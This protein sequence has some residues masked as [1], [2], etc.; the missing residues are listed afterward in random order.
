MGHRLGRRPAFL[1]VAYGFT[2]IMLGGTIPTPLYP[3]YQ[4]RLGFSSLVVTL[5]FAAY[6]A[7]TLAALLLCG[8]LS[9]QVGR[10]PVLL[11]GLG[12]AVA[13]TAVFVL[14]QDLLGLF[15]GRALSGF[16]VGLFTGA[17]TAALAELYPGADRGRA[18]LVAS[19]VQMGGLGL[20]PLLSGLLSQYAPAPTTLCYL[21][22][23]ALLAPVGLVL[24]VPETVA[25]PGRPQLR[26]QRLAVP[27]RIRA[28]FAAAGAAG[29]AAF[30]FLGLLTALVGRFL[31]SSLHSHSFALAGLMIFTLFLAVV[32][33]QLLG[34]RLPTRRALLAGLGLLP[35]G[36][37][38]FV[39]ALPTGS[40][41]LFVAGIVLGGLGVGL[42]F[43]AA[44]A[45]V[46][47]L[48]PEDQRAEVVSAFFV[49]AYLGITVP[50]IGIGILTTLAS[51]LVAAATFAG[52][53]TT[54]AAGAGW[55]IASRTGDQ[56]V[57]RAS[58]SPSV[59]G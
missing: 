1:V 44:L 2:V 36:L 18:T 38:L 10:R 14:G 23:L 24:V 34:A 15:V 59:R 42:A 3:I 50:V 55:V 21:A 45:L 9:D 39:L 22:F 46:G 4:D 12:V 28:P 7:G 27:S 57:T 25:K 56:G 51:T 30:A 52:V 53:V 31:A 6:A 26:V 8:R 33:A 16:S 49:L 58:P 37:L 54:L 32:A 40:L 41:G 5:V 13:S 47:Q 17:A 19:C 29:F 43:R 48:A 35:G 11:G 20:G